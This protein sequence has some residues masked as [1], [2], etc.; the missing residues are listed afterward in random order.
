MRSLFFYIFD[1][2][3]HK[4]NVNLGLLNATAKKSNDQSGSTLDQRGT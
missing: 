3:I 2:E 4:Y 1:I